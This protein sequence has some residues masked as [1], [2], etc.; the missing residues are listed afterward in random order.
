MKQRCEN[1]KA[2]SF[3]YY[4]AKG[5]SV[6]EEWQTFTGFLEWALSHGYDENLTIDRIDSNRNYD[7]TN[8]RWA[9]CKEQQNNTSYNR[10]YTYMGETHNVMQWA[11]KFGLPH[12]T[13]YNRLRRGW[14]FEKA[15]TTK[16]RKYREV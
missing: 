11:E 7:P 3:K 4:G 8:C 14:N 16:R 2:I 10:L 13:L 1:P 9:T 5:I 12:T 6:C 15:I